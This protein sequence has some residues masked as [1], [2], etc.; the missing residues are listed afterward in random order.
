MRRRP[1][2][3]R[4]LALA[5]GSALLLSSTGCVTAERRANRQW[6]RVSLGMTREAVE[7]ELGE[8]DSRE[9]RAGQ[10]TWHFSY[11]PRL[12]PGKVAATSGQVIGVLMVVG[13]FIL[14]LY[15][16]SRSGGPTQTPQLGDIGGPRGDGSTESDTVHF[17]VVFGQTGRV[18]SVSGIA[19]C[20]E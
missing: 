15:A 18:V 19:A 8:P 16:A 17:Y 11:G 20:D 4:G 10:E 3:V 1:S 14:I 9:E 12:D 5:L 6:N 7:L 13:I 2:S